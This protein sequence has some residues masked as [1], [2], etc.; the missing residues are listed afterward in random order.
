MGLSCECDYDP[1]P[2]QTI[3]YDPSDYAPLASSRA[4][5][6]CSC[7]GKIKP[8]DLAAKVPR[9]KIPASDIE[10]KIYGEEGEIPRAPKFMCERCA[11]LFFSLT[12]LGYCGEP[13]EDQRELIKEYAE[14]RAEGGG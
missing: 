8:G 4:R 14:L 6:C 10:I 2:G 12:E 13:W 5:K 3:W 11:D 1:E 9:Y 7:K